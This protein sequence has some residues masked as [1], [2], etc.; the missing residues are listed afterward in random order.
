[1]I[2]VLVP[3]RL[4]LQVVGAG[5]R[6][7]KKKARSWNTVQRVRPDVSLPALRCVWKAGRRGVVEKEGEP[8]GKTEGKTETEDT[9]LETLRMHNSQLLQSS[10]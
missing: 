3:R 2:G 1:M 4:S 7:K 6:K 9:N 8:E 10:D 5:E